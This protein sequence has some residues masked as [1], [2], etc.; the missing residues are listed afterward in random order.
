MKLTLA[1]YSN[2][3]Q[4]FDSPFDAVAKGVVSCAINAAIILLQHFL[5]FN[6]HK[7]TS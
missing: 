7:T 3:K 5:Y 2:V 4:T 6:A 1:S